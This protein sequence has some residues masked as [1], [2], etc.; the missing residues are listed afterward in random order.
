[1]NIAQKRS[2][3]NLAM[4]KISELNKKMAEIQVYLD[5]DEDKNDYSDISKFNRKMQSLDDKSHYSDRINRVKRR[6]R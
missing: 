1:M 3:A 2:I 6:K 4:A 5:E